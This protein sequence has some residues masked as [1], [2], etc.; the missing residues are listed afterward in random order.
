MERPVNQLERLVS[1]VQRIGGAIIARVGW[2]APLLARV[3]VGTVF[4][5]TGWGKL[6]DLDKVT[7]YF[8]D[9]GIPMAHLNAIMAAF[10]EFVCGCLLV[11]GLGARFAA[12][13]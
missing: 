3:A 11:A 13:P 1:L 8:T 6:Q 12:L 4:I 5:G 9:L 10:T 7:A 2:F